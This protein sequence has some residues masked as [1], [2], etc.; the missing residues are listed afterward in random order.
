MELR[1]AFS[2]RT[3]SIHSQLRGKSKDNCSPLNKIYAKTILKQWGD[4]HQ[5]KAPAMNDEPAFYRNL[6]RAL[7]ARYKTQYFLNLK[8]RWDDSIIDFTTVDFLSLNRT[9]R[10]RE[11][12]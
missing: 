7:D 4:V 3:I 6:E 10:I 9:G 11:G 2:L 12:L 5:L 8:P 1:I